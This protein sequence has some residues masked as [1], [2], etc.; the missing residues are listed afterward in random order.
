MNDAML[1]RRRL[2]GA[3]RR[4]GGRGTVGAWEVFGLS[5]EFREAGTDKG[6]IW[7]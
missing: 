4:S 3:P 2:A 7:D 1:R 5:R 6:S